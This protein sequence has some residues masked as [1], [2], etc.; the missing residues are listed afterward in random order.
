MTFAKTAATAAVL[1]LM[2]GGTAAM[3]AE[4]STAIGCMHMSKKVTAALQSKQDA[5][6]YAAAREQ[7]DTAKAFCS[8]GM[9]GPGVQGYEKV[10]EMLGVS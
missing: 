3:A 8:Q 5:P 1:S 10:L 7:A 4:Q 6:N 9:Y 2:L